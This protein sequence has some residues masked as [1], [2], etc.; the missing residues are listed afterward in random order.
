MRLRDELRANGHVGKRGA[1]QRAIDEGKVTLEE[2]NEVFEDRTISTRAI[3]SALRARGIGSVTTHMVV[4]Y[5][6]GQGS[7]LRARVSA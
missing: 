6:T 4:Y 7:A 2:L 1:L 5:R 3:T